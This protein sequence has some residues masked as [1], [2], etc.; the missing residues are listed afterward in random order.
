MRRRGLARRATQQL[1]GAGTRAS[2]RGPHRRQ[3]LR[4]SSSVPHCSLPRHPHATAAGLPGSQARA[5]DRRQ[6]FSSS[7]G[8]RTSGSASQARPRMYGCRMSASSAA[9][10]ASAARRK[11]S[12]TN[13]PASAAARSR[14]ARRSLGAQ[15]RVGAPTLGAARPP[16]TGRS[17]MQGCP[18]HHA[19]AAARLHGSHQRTRVRADVRVPAKRCV[20]HADWQRESPALQGRTFTGRPEIPAR[21]GRQAGAV[22]GEAVRWAPAQQPSGAS[23]VARITA[24]GP[25]LASADEAGGRPSAVAAL[26]APGETPGAAASAAGAA[27]GAGVGSGTVRCLR[28]GARSCVRAQRG[29]SAHAQWAWRCWTC[30]IDARLCLATQPPSAMG[31]EAARR[32]RAGMQRCMRGGRP[33]GSA[34][35]PHCLQPPGACRRFVF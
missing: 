7:Q 31:Q 33:R 15:V 23:A 4:R 32:L 28:A 29:L 18:A 25:H 10:A 24:I 13:A 2:A 8:A 22:V 12:G 34:T 26:D 35:K 20:S 19:P 14:D 1:H 17:R 21:I 3:A 11:G 27:S 9:G 16:G 5:P 30:S 6:A